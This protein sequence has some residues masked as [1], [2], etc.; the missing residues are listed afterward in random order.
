MSA[1]GAAILE[2]PRGNVSFDPEYYRI[3]ATRMLDEAGVAPCAARKTGH[4]GMLS[5]AGIV[6]NIKTLRKAVGLPQCF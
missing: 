4:H 3:I 2:M 1:A 6:Q 5:A